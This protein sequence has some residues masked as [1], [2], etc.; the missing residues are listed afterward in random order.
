MSIIYKLT[1]NITG[2]FYIGKT[3]STLKARLKGHIKVYKT[4]VG[5]LQRS[6]RI[7]G[8]ENFS[9]SL[10]EETEFELLDER[11]KFYIDK[12]KPTLNMT[13]GGEGGSTTHNYIWINDGTTNKYV[14]NIDGVPEGYVR[15]RINS[16]F[17]DPI[18]QAEMSAKSDRA[19]A[20]LST[21]I[22]YKEGRAKKRKQMPS[23]VFHHSEETKEK[24]RKPRGKQKNPHKETRIL[25]C[26]HCNKIGK[27][28]GML[29]WHFD[30][31][32]NKNG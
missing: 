25:T 23:G 15:G 11:E 5:H 8:I 12:L 3:K 32:R 18:F 29:V 27:L 28:R 24:L 1:N 10:I 16:K 22:T 9:I 13:Q 14:L 6:M 21:S 7:H 19:A 31:C 20:G 2:E 26:P 4:G 30:N 17:N